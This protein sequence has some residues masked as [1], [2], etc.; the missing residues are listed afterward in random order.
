M[1]APQEA[2]E[3]ASSGAQNCS[4]PF[5]DFEYNQMV[6]MLTAAAV[7]R[8]ATARERAKLAL[9]ES[10]T[11]NRATYMKL[12][13][14]AMGWHVHGTHVFSIPT[15]TV[16]PVDAQPRGVDR[17]FILDSIP[18][19]LLPP[20][21]VPGQ[22]PGPLPARPQ[23]H[24][25]PRP[26]PQAQPDSKSVGQQQERQAEQQQRMPTRDIWSGTSPE[27]CPDEG[28]GEGGD[29]GTDESL[30]RM[31]HSFFHPFMPSR[32][33]WWSEHPE[34]QAWMKQGTDGCEA[35]HR[36][37]MYDTL[38]SVRSIL[39]QWDHNL[40]E[41]KAINAP[42]EYK[43]PPPGAYLYSSSY[44]ERRGC[45]SREGEQGA[46][47]SLL[48][49]LMHPL[50]LVAGKGKG[51]NQGG[52]SSDKKAEPEECRC[53]A[54]HCEAADCRSQS[55]HDQCVRSRT[56]RGGA[57]IPGNAGAWSQQG[58]SPMQRQLAMDMDSTAATYNCWTQP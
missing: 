10:G 52:G 37:R 56:G 48:R 17:T 28:E 2:R 32:S 53:S 4:A 49:M 14:H 50:S 31:L 3:G 18:T 33:V 34:F 58:V 23:L 42:H 19:M 46:I 47:A 7:L 16:S 35:I 38:D 27:P 24:T 51:T 11:C 55:P 8:A 41:M 12:K 9:L 6:L 13:A 15:S 30:M 43:P 57:G 29:C 22:A 40:R 20:L 1:V 54:R 5:S 25:A 44:S 26:I 36:K 21:S 39:A 45:N